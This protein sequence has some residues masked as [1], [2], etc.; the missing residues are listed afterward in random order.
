MN[1]KLIV[2]LFVV[3]FILSVVLMF[4][5]MSIW[6]ELYENFT[7]EPFE[8][9]YVT[10]GA[11]TGFPLWAWMISD[12]VRHSRVAWVWFMIIFNIPIV[13]FYALFIFEEN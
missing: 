2:N 13:I 1:K 4:I 10:L 12:A 11:I 7:L 8:I 9:V 3:V 6:P 5:N